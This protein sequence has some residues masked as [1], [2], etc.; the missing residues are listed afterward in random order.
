[1][2]VTLPAVMKHAGKQDAVETMKAIRL[3]KDNFK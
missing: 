1:M 2:R 3:E